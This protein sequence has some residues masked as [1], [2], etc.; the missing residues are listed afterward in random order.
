MAFKRFT[1]AA[2]GIRMNE[3]R[4]LY[5]AV[6]VPKITYAADLW[7]RPKISRKTD[8]NLTENGPRMLTK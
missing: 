3:A 1:K 2:A 8:H 5:N 4:K 7:F 6:A